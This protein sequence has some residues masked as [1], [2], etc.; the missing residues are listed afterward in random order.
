MV[1]VSEED[2]I[3]FTHRIPPMYTDMYLPCPIFRIDCRVIALT[4]QG[5]VTGVRQCYQ[6]QV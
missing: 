3:Q 1:I 2:S 4:V 5:S 6:L